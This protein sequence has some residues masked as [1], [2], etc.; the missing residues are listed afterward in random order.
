[1]TRHPCGYC[2]RPAPHARLCPTCTHRT[3]TLLQA[4]PQWLRDLDDAHLTTHNAGPH[5]QPRGPKT[6]PMPC[7][8]AIAALLDQLDH[9]LRWWLRWTTR[10][11]NEPL[12]ATPFHPAR[13]LAARTNWLAQDP[14][15][16]AL[17]DVLETHNSAVTRLTDL[18]ADQAHVPLPQPCPDCGGQITATVHD[19]APLHLDCPGCGQTWH[20]W[21]LRR[22]S[23]RMAHAS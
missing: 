6:T 21:Q 14:D 20:A 8:P 12:P 19:N 13:W 11:R 4:I 16:D 9:D 10:Q 15:A 23:R 22:L 18:P 5:R 3:R 1:M 2:T 7:R 17:L